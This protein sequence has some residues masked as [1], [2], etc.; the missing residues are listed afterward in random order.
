MAVGV[1]ERRPP[2]IISASGVAATSSR[3]AAVIRIVPFLLSH[4]CVGGTVW[5]WASS[6]SFGSVV[7]LALGRHLG[8]LQQDCKVLVIMNPDIFK[9]RGDIRVGTKC[10]DRRRFRVR[11]KLLVCRRGQSL[12]LPIC[13]RECSSSKLCNWAS[14]RARLD[15][16][17]VKTVGNDAQVNC[18]VELVL[19]VWDAM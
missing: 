1:V 3:P 16:A 8:Q 18:F 14:N 7:P 2:L 13:R 17:L 10:G 15:V 9:S 12:W 19:L 4:V 5:G 11:Q 6:S